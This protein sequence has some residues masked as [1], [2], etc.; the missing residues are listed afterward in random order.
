[1]VGRQPEL[2]AVWCIRPWLV[3]KVFCLAAQAFHYSPFRYQIRLPVAQR[4]LPQ[5]RFDTPSNS[6]GA[7][8]KPSAKGR[9][10]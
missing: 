8:A 9:E 4:T 7:L 3:L 10:A 5:F 1:L 6:I 2:Q